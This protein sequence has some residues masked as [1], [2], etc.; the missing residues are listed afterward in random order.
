MTTKEV[1]EKLNGVEYG[2][3]ESIIDSEVLKENKLVIVYGYSDDLMEFTGSISDEFG[4]Y[5]GGTAYLDSDG[6]VPCLCDDDNCPYYLSK[7][8]KAITIKSKWCEVDGYGWTFVTEIPHHT[9]DIIEDDGAKN[10][11]IVFSMLDLK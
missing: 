11:G 10:Q 1:A 4:C 5:G 6:I 3:E 9:F 2:Q 7:V 8:K